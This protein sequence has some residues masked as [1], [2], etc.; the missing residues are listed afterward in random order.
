MSG[1]RPI[2][3]RAWRADPAEAW[4]LGGLLLVVAPHFARMSGALSALCL[5]LLGWR[6]LAAF[7]RV[8]LPGRWLRVLLTFA[9]VGAVFASYHTL[10]GRHAGVA[11]LVVMLCLKLLEMKGPRD[12][13]VAI[14]LG[15]FVVITGF[16]FGQSVFIGVYMLVVVVVLTT[17]LIAHQHRAREWGG[18]AGQRQHL[19]TAAVLVAQAAPMMLVL[20]VLFPR[21][22]GPLWGMP[23]DAF[24]A[25]TGLSDT[26]SPGNIA[27]LSDDDAVAFR[28]RFNGGPPPP[29]QRYWRG[30]VLW[31]FDGYTWSDPD[32]PREVRA[33]PQPIDYR[34]LGPALNYTVTVEPHGRFWLFALDLPARVPG[35]ATLTSAYQLLSRHPVQGVRRYRM[36]SYPQYRLD[37]DTAPS[38]QRYLALPRDTAPRARALAARWRA[39]AADAAGVVRE[40]L[41]YFR[42]QPFYYTR[43]PPATPGDPVDGFL[44]ETRRGYCEHYASAFAVL[45]RAAGIPARV[46][47][48]YQGGEMNPVGDYLIV[49][50][51]DAHAWA[52]VWLRGTG[53]ERVD[54]TAVIPPG[55]IDSSE[56]LARI[57]PDERQNVER[58][59]G[60]WL[61]RTWR[62]L[63]YR[64]DSLNYYWNQWVVGF[65]RRRQNTLLEQ[66]G[67]GGISWRGTAG[68]LF[69]SL[70]VIVLA[71]AAFVLLRRRATPSDPVQRCWRRFCAK[72]ARR[73][74]VRGPAEGA[75]DFAQRV[76]RQRPELAAQVSAI[77]AL[78]NRLRY[79]SA[80]AKRDDLERLGRAV[81]AFR[82]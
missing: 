5:G 17:A 54:P 56:D 60:D 75:Q 41:A 14:F 3:R 16:L 23:K 45:M 10:V 79:S 7:S 39:Q 15:Y 61:T 33:P 18:W 48:G 21:I 78:Y 20:F 50:Q 43:E 46:V 4:L 24:T 6:V 72:L 70:G 13:T 67:L 53:W 69:A 81:R 12:T 51:S 40:A 38:P 80:G 62:G 26:L 2:A 27:R 66:L 77:A 44:F 22:P 42:K 65:D 8:R 71:L 58:Q 64:W 37:P 28:V 82:P 36:R 63:G 52:E 74:L 76:R 49:R 68:L 35:D 32:Q 73:G 25:H 55:R 59:R 11:L 34:A 57:R 31:D 30:P 47:T 9:A 1:P 29:A 19:R